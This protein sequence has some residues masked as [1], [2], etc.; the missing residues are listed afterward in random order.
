M[1]ITDPIADMITR[2]SNGQAATKQEINLPLSK[3]K[4]AICEVLKKEGYILDFTTSKNEGKGILT[5]NLKYFNG[6]PVI[7]Q[8]K[9]VSK[10]DCRV[11]KQKN[12]LPKVL[13]GLGISI[14]TTSAGIMTDK[15]ARKLG[16]G[17]EVLCLV[18]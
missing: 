13:S 8:F 4:V 1:S 3:I 16:Y 10:P 15:N 12:E 2:I 6:I 18:A 14:I 9:R 7:K 5:I 11:Y 17:G